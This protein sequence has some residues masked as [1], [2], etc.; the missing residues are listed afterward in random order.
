M[1]ALL[2]VAWGLA[3]FNAG[4]ALT[5]VPVDWPAFAISALVVIGAPIMGVIASRNPTP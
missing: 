5:A 4:R 1:N 3:L 2:V